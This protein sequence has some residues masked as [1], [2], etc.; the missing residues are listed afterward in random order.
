MSCQSTCSLS[1]SM[2]VYKTVRGGEATARRAVPKYIVW[3]INLK[4]RLNKKII[5]PPAESCA[6]EVVQVGGNQ[7]NAVTLTFIEIAEWFWN[8]LHCWSVYHYQCTEIRITERWSVWPRWGQG[9]TN[10]NVYV[11]IYLVSDAYV[12]SFTP[13]MLVMSGEYNLEVS[14]IEIP[15][16]VKNSIRV[17]VQFIFRA[18]RVVGIFALDILSLESLELS[19]LE[20]DILLWWWSVSPVS[21]TVA[22]DEQ[23]FSHV[24]ELRRSAVF[25]F[26]SCV[27]VSCQCLYIL[28]TSDIVFVRR[29]L[30][31]VASCRAAF[32]SQP[33]ICFLS[34]SASSPSGERVNTR[35]GD[36]RI[37]CVY[38]VCLFCFGVFFK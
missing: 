6:Q 19:L 7:A 11:C 28:F 25:W 32:V 15:R 20:L 3:L 31:K 9:I 5:Q 26:S 16:Y 17:C 30:G 29:A 38:F 36:K 24:S 34:P 1:H 37:V 4:E 10:C 8:Y 22:S 13:D 18:S 23:W 21:S 12:S 33:L 27:A 2:S 14:L 35:P